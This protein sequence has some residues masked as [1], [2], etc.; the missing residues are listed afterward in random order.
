[1]V[2]LRTSLLAAAIAAGLSALLPPSAAAW[3]R[4]TLQEAAAAD[5]PVSFEMFLPPRENPALDALIAAQTTPG[6]PQYHH[7]LTADQYRAQFGTDQATMDQAAAE[8]Q[9]HGFTVIAR[10][11]HGLRVSGSVGAVERA[12]GTTLRMARFADGH[13]TIAAET[14]LVLTPTLAARQ[15]VIAAFS[16][17]IRMHVD[18][19]SGPM[20]MNRD[21]SGGPYWFT[22]LKQAYKLPSYKELNGD[23]ATIGIL[24]SN[25][26]RKKD[27]DAYFEHE[28]LA[29]PDLREIKIDGGSPFDPEESKEVQL[30]IQQS[31]GMAPLAHIIH[32]NIPDLSDGHISDALIQIVEDR[33]V[34]IINMSFGGPERGYAPAFNKGHSYFDVLRSENLLFRQGASEGITFVASTGDLGARSIPALACLEPNAKPGC[35]GFLVSAE[36]PATSP[37]V[38]AVGGTNLITTYN[39]NDPD[40]L[41]SA[42][43]SEN[44]YPDPLVADP[45]F[46]T[47]ATDPEWGSGGGIS[48]IFDKPTYQSLVQTGS[49]TRRTVPDVAGHMGGCI[50]A[51]VMPCEPDRSADW[52]AISD[53]FIPLHGT[54]ASAPDFSGLVALRIQQD[55]SRQGLINSLVY[56][57]AAAQAAG[58]G[59]TV[60]R[61]DI[62]GD[63]GYYV[64]HP[65]YN[66]VLGNGT[67]YGS[68]F[69]GLPNGPFAGKPQTPSNP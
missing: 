14:P 67:I 20:P 19:V 50:S 65:G 64:T 34:D 58:T 39:P 52:V 47:P 30:D 60:F 11:A 7:F 21:G 55:G 5:A 62:P 42:Y 35:G 27:I 2:R 46:G 9:A 1:M 38:A 51:A 43:V 10:H 31:G 49:Y 63:N 23:G 8:L 16:P 36:F 3:E 17:V 61:T 32:Y 41:N 13:R 26:Y 25:A 40:N 12:F 37:Y 59:P 4:A 68:A 66:L 22:D 28:K 56:S 48:M 29:P 6:S 69:V 44:A 54:S 53:T 33:K 57:M 45:F 18:S 15:A 24:V